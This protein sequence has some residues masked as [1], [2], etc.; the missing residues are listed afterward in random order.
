MASHFEQLEVWQE[1]IILVK[2]IYMLCAGFPADERF[3]LSQQLKRAAVSI[4][5]NIAEGQQRD[6]LK[7]YV[8][9]LSIA[10]GSH[11][12]VR[13]QL[14][15]AKELQLASEKEV[16]PIIEKLDKVGRMLHGLQRSLKS[17]LPK[18]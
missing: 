13:T 3:G 8:R 17:K 12:E 1:S 9:F 16:V 14:V 6:S 4:P 2:M 11:A 7:D 5:S 10:S 15:L 18:P